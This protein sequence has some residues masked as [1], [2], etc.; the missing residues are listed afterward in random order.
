MVDKILM[1][2]FKN[3][4]N[5]TASLLL[6][7]SL[8]AYPTTMS[9]PVVKIK[10]LQSYHDF[11]QRN[12]G[13]CELDTSDIISLNENIWALL[14]LV[15]TQVNQ[16]IYFTLDIN[17]Y[18]YEEFWNYPTNGNGDCEDYA[19]EKRRRLV[20]HNIPRGAL[21]MITGFHS[22]KLYAHALLSIETDQ[23][24]LILDNE[25]NDILWWDEKPYI[26]EKREISNQQWE[27]FEQ[28]W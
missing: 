23:G 25:T 22:T 24:T 16:E 20:Q 28:N 12:P 15:N 19:L 6:T 14:N 9:L 10:S 11:C 2:S 21:R 17:Q 3:I 4:L 1:S 27:Y 18:G 5:L 13:E 8:N 7:I 26:Y